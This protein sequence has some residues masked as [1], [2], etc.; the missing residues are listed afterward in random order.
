[1]KLAILAALSTLACAA[2]QSYFVGYDSLSPGPVDPNPFKGLSYGDQF[3]V[4]R[5][6]KV[7]PTL[8]RPKKNPNV[9]ALAPQPPG[10]F[11][12]SV[13]KAP[14]ADTFAAKK[15]SFACVTDQKG[16]TVP[17]DCTV[18][19]EGMQNNDLGIPKVQTAKYASTPRLQRVDFE[20]FTDLR[21]LDFTVSKAG[22]DDKLSQDVTL[23]LDNF[24]YVVNSK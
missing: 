2:S 4:A 12:G 11:L 14:T 6:A 22:E 24:A 19:F 21:T 1:M 15:I 9:L 8:Y 13:R 7:A 20:G 23:I 10:K 16:K 5:R 18:L 3:T 17:V